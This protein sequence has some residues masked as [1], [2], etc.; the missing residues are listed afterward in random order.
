MR[1]VAFRKEFANNLTDPGRAFGLFTFVA[2]TDKPDSAGR[3]HPK[4]LILPRLQG[5][6]RRYN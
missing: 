6:S 4:S 5:A 3:L 2:A 1:S